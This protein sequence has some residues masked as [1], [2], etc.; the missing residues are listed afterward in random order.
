MLL[1]SDETHV[2]VRAFSLIM[3]NSLG[4]SGVQF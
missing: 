1:A 2:M 3:S 4:N